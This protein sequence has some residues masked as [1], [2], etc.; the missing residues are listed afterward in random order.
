MMTSGEYW[1]SVTTYVD[2]ILRLT[3]EASPNELCSSRTWQRSLDR[4]TSDTLDGAFLSTADALAAI[5]HTEDGD[6]AFFE[7]YG[8]DALKGCQSTREVYVRI[9]SAAFRADVMERLSQRIHDRNVYEEEHEDEEE[10]GPTASD[11]AN[12]RRTLL[13]R[14][15][16]ETDDGGPEPIMTSR[17]Y[18][19]VWIDGEVTIHGSVWFRLDSDGDL[20][21]E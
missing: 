16:D 7:T 18:A 11:V 10:D 13:D 6:H 8:L 2:E 20:I 14:M 3:D 21:D 5:V 12:A 17:G 1:D 19:D 4:A 15:A 9:G